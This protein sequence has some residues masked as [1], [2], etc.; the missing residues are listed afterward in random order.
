M[1]FTVTSG[2]ETASPSGKFCIP[3]PMAKFRADSNVAESVL[4]MAPKLTPTAKPSGILCTVMAMT[5]RPTITKCTFIN[6]FRK[7]TRWALVFIVGIRTSSMIRF[8]CDSALAWLIACWLAV[9]NWLFWLPEP[10]L[11]RLRDVIKLECCW[12]RQSEKLSKPMVVH[13]SSIVWTA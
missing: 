11:T 2:S 5:Y 1:N 12:F 10:D 3:I 13:W 4:P 6:E 8:H 7:I 9:Y